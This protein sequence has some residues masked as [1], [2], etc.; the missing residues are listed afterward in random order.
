[1][2]QPPSWYPRSAQG[3]RGFGSICGCARF[4]DRPAQDGVGVAAGAFDGVS[5]TRTELQDRVAATGVYRRIGDELQ[6]H[7]RMP[8]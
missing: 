1:M 5:G 6:Q 2:R 8:E 4:F 3:R 7:R